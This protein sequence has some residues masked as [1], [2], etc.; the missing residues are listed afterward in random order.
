MLFLKGLNHSDFRVQ[1]KKNRVT[2][3]F[4]KFEN[5][6]FLDRRANHS[7]PKTTE[8]EVTLRSMNPR[9]DTVVF[10]LFLV[11]ET[12][13]LLSSP[14]EPTVSGAPLGPPI[15]E[16]TFFRPTLCRLPQAH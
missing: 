7:D 4:K 3:I 5:F 10:R 13:G 11:N 8:S 15:I 16:R 2:N 1:L 14:Q 9:T 12:H 6:H